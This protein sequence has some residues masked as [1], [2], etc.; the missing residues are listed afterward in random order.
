MSK[1]VKQ[2]KATPKQRKKAMERADKNLQRERN[3]LIASGWAGEEER[4]KL[5]YNQSIQKEEWKKKEKKMNKEYLDLVISYINSPAKTKRYYRDLIISELNKQEHIVEKVNILIY[6]SIKS[7]KQGRLVD[8]IDVL[9]HKDVLLWLYLSSA[10]IYKNLFLLR[11]D[12]IYTLI[13]STGK[14]N[15]DYSWGLILTAL[16]GESFHRQAAIDGLVEMEGESSREKLE[17]LKDNDPCSSVRRLA[18][19]RLEELNEEKKE[20]EK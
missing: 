16:K 19:E 15:E 20:E 18:K 3:K 5:L 1:T 6:E 8:I 17:H 11:D 13:V 10:N 4:K 2:L 7:N 9:S 14:R 12:V